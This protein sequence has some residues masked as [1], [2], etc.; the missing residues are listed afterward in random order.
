MSKKLDDLLPPPSRDRLKAREI[1]TAAVRKNV[2]GASKA[3]LESL[4]D[5][6]FNEL[7][8]M[9]P[10]DDVKMEDL[11]DRIDVLE[12]ELKKSRRKK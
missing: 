1:H 2:A 3:D 12:A 8:S 6:A 10:N 7:D 5:A 9:N 4:I 11:L